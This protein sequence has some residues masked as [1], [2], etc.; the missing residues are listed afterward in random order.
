M[1]ETNTTPN[2]TIRADLLAN[3]Y[4]AFRVAADRGAYKIEEYGL[5]SEIHKAVRSEWERHKEAAE[6]A[7]SA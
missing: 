4:Q 7:E 6:S 1:T 3:L 5:V 2:I